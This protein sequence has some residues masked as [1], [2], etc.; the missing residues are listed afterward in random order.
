[1]HLTGKENEDFR[2]TNLQRAWDHIDL[3]KKGTV[4]VE[5]AHQ[6][7]RYMLNNVEVSEGLQVQLKEEGALANQYRPNPIQAPW[8]PGAPD[9]LAPTSKTMIENGFAPNG[10][11]NHLDYVRTPP[12][13]YSTEN[14]DQLMKSLITN[15]ATEKKDAAGG[16]TG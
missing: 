16:P 8:A 14:D 10:A 15:Y 6:L 5:E 1:M 3:L 13:M 7:F 2:L 12:D 11:V 9:P 4:P